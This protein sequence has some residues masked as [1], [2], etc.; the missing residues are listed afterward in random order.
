MDT[1]KTKRPLNDTF[2]N[3]RTK[4]IKRDDNMDTIRA[5]MKQKIEEIVARSADNGTINEFVTE[6]GLICIQPLKSAID[7]QLLRS[8]SIKEIRGLV[9]LAIV[10]FKTS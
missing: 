7:Q 8:M 9:R 4:K 6:K 2:K 3:L 5:S 10:K 1:F